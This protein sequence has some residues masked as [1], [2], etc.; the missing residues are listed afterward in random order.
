MNNCKIVIEIIKP[1]IFLFLLNVLSYQYQ[2]IIIVLK[3]FY[4]I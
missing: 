3:K 4:D 1:L 2:F